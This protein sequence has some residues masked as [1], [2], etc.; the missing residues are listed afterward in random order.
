[1]GKLYY[2]RSVRPVDFPTTI[3]DVAL[4]F[5]SKESLSHKKLQKLCYYT[6]AWYLAFYRRRLFP[7]RFEA[8]IHGPV[9]P[10]LYRAYREY[11]W[12]DIP[13][14]DPPGL[15]NKVAAHLDA[16]WGAYGHLTGHQLEAIA[17][18]EDPWKKARPGLESW[19]PS[20][21][22]L[23]DSTIIAFYLAELERNQNE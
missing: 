19:Q 22:P 20:T 23:D 1:V 8:W 7:E 21:N 13:K 15:S 17:H 18:Q 12:D 9:C 2:L 3:A 14:A 16:V 5:R 6:Y 10:D 11:G 4:Y